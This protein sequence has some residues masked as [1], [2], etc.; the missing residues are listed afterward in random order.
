MSNVPP[1]QPPP[2]QPPPFQP[3]P[4]S[5]GPGVPP[6]AWGPPPVGGG[7]DPGAYGAPVAASPPKKRRLLASVAV[8]VV[9][10]GL[11]GAALAA[12]LFLRGS[13]DHLSKLAPN[14][15]VVYVTAY[16]DP[17]GSQKL[18]LNNLVGKFPAVSDATKRDQSIN[19]FLDTALQDTGLT[20]N[21][22]RD[23]LGQQIGF[24]VSATALKTGTGSSP[25]VAA[26]ISTTDDSK[27]N[28]ALSKL[29]NGPQGAKE[30]YGSDNH[31]GVDITTVISGSHIVAAY[32][33]VDHTLVVAGNVAY[34]DN[35]IDTDQGKQQ[36]LESTSDYTT[37]K[38]QLPAD[39][40]AFLYVDIP[41][42]ASGIRNLIQS[43]GT[44]SASTQKAL[45]QLNALLG[46]GLTLSAQSDGF[47]LDSVTDYDAN[48]LDDKTRQSLGISPHE[49][50]T[51]ALVPADRFLYGGIT[52]FQFILQSLTDTV[53]Q[54]SP[55]AADKLDQIGLTQITGH[56]SGD[57]GIEI[58][59]GADGKTPA[60]SV[61]VA[62][63][64]ENAM[65][66][67]LD[68][69]LP[70]LLGHDATVDHETYKG[71]DIS[72]ASLATSGLG[73]SPAPKVSWA[74]VHGNAV[75]SS[76]PDE[77]K[78]IID[79]ASGGANITSSPV[80]QQQVG[81]ASKNNGELYIDVQKAIAAI[82]ANLP[83]DQK[84]SFDQN[85]LPNLQPITAIVLTETNAGDHTSGH[86]LVA[87][88]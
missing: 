76:S 28:A 86:L 23:W 70:T 7:A 9:V 12:F 52:G 71:I 78:A 20:H 87:V 79:T 82:E 21:D 80:Y 55:S 61:V 74:V 33:I 85:V 44:S 73:S 17:S 88:H 38:S 48:K 51:A 67:F 84:A 69:A 22:I 16:V 77:M 29:R 68:T 45:D 58:G 14:D 1:Y 62:T 47:A 59:V 10:A 56:I 66:S 27:T 30:T 24:I 81:S 49:N 3:V 4:P 19:D 40:L 6:P 25:S 31:G 83:A 57:A 72:E 37:V 54:A 34:L 75:I 15:T 42:I 63:D 11:A 8:F 36:S 50:S 5:T 53:R 60:G 26:L 39:N 32:A 43:S 35:I 13:A 41:Q 64:D 18:N 2:F 46:A 65:R